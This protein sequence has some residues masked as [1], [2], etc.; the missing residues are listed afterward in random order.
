MNW[1]IYCYKKTLENNTGNNRTKEDDIRLITRIL[2]EIIQIRKRL[3][4]VIKY[5][6]GPFGTIHFNAG[7]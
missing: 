5:F 1:T 7:C 3:Y 4:R 2:N 6:T